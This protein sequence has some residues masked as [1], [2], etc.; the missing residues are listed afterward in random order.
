MRTV[1]LRACVGFGATVKRIVALPT[2]SAGTALPIHETS[3]RPVHRQPSSVVTPIDTCPPDG[4]MFTLDGE[5]SRR[6]GAAAWTTSIVCSLTTTRPRRD[7]P[8]G[9][10]STE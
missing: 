7:I 9:L 5:T 3:L 4:P 1:P 10:G 6:Q 2:P 8:A